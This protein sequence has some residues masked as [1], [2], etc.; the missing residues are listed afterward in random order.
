MAQIV[1][2]KVFFFFDRKHVKKM[3]ITDSGEKGGKHVCH[4]LSFGDRVLRDD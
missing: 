1:T 3:V 4:I 2:V